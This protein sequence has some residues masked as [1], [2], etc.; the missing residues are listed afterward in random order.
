MD[1]ALDRYLRGR[2]T[3]LAGRFRGNDKQKEQ[4]KGMRAGYSAWE[5]KV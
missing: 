1:G 5:I 2:D 4:Y 3:I